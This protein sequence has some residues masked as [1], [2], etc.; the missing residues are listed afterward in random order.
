[1]ALAECLA[2]CLELDWDHQ[3]A[4]ATDQN[5]AT[6]TGQTTDLL[7][8]TATDHCLGQLTGLLKAT[9]TDHCLG[10]MTDRH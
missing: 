2:Q 8:A 1:M 10:Q 7:K 5:S 6:A 4:M 9:A 3:T